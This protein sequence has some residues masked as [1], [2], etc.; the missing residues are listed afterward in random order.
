MVA[1]GARE[2]RM[3]RTLL[4]VLV[5]RGVFNRKQSMPVSVVFAANRRSHQTRAFTQSGS[6]TYCCDTTFGGAGLNFAGPALSFGT[7]EAPAGASP[8]KIALASAA[9]D[10]IRLKQAQRP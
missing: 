4:R 10:A 8:Q 2:W 5:V 1:E 6:E 9:S 3:G 7:G